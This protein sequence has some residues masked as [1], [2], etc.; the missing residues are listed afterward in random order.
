VYGFDNDYIVQVCLIT[1]ANEIMLYSAF[2]CLFVY[3]YGLSL[4]IATPR[5]Y[6]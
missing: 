2:V 1:S 3:V 4:C 5:T 6:Y